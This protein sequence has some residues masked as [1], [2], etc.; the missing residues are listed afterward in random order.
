M[1]KAP[2]RRASR[3]YELTFESRPEFLYARVA[4]PE[5]N[6]SLK[7]DYLAEVLLACARSRCKQILLERD[8]PVM[9]PDEEFA[10][11]VEEVVRASENVA[12][13]FVNGHKTIE[14]KLKKFVAESK[15]RGGKFRY[16]NDRS[17]AEK[18]LLDLYQ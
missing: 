3:P 17:K 15:K 2:N 16:F 5:I 6:R 10:S 4:A 1:A 13:A 11:T 12:I 18:W 14:P 7:L 8:I 9:V